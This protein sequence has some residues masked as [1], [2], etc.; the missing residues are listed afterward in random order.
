MCIRDRDNPLISNSIEIEVVVDAESLTISGPTEVV[1]KETEKYEAI[2]SPSDAS[3]KNIIWSVTPITGDGVIEQDGSFTATKPGRV[4]IT[5]VSEANNEVFDSI[6]ISVIEKIECEDFE[7]TNLKRD[8]SVGEKGSYQV[9]F[10]PNDCNES[11]SFSSS[12]PEIFKVDMDG[13][14]EAIAKGEVKLVA[15]CGNITK[16]YAITINEKVENPDNTGNASEETNQPKT[17]DSN[18]MWIWIVVIALAVAVIVALL[19]VRHVR[20]KKK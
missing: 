17:G 14:W 3:N 11:L 8:L 9:E 6:E 15:K 10:L 1:C 5:A 18:N 4:L 19:V 12:N 2:V 20:S 7:V 13:N 16:T